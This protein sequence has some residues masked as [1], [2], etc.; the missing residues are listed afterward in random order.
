MPGGLKALLARVLR[1]P[2]RERFLDLL[3]KGSVGAEIGVFRGH[4]TREI[5]RIVQP[6]QLH[7]VDGWWLLYG[8]Q[9]P[10]WGPYTDHGRLKTRDAYE[11]VRAIL[12]EHDHRDA[13]VLHVADDL[14]CLAGF[15]PGTFDW[16]Y[17][18]SSHEYEH[19]RKELALLAPRMKP[20][21]LIAGDDWQDDPSHEHHG[22]AR[23]V[24]EFCAVEGWT[25]AHRDAF[26][27]WLIR[28]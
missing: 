26:C 24:R 8:E 11:E 7:L 28:R 21:G 10:D 27:Q 13:A 14:E 2:R 22:V 15:P 1:R 16:V 23:A 19:T 3:P 25:L 18:D 17:L 4:Y 9:Y 20:D 6:S 5:L 12:R